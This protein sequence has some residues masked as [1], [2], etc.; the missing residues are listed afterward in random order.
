M[1]VKPSY[2]DLWSFF[3]IQHLSFF[4]GVCFL[5]LSLGPD[6]WCC[7]SPKHLSSSL[8]RVLLYWGWGPFGVWLWTRSTCSM[9]SMELFE[10]EMVPFMVTGLSHLKHSCEF[11]SSREQDRKTERDGPLQPNWTVSRC[12]GQRL[13]TVLHTPTDKVCCATYAILIQLLCLSYCVYGRSQRKVENICFQVGLRRP[14]SGSLLGKPFPVSVDK[15]WARWT[16][17]SPSKIT[18]SLPICTCGV[19]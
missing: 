17:L 19:D 6:S 16:S 4:A 18:S 7:Q 8:W 14:L 10:P 1:F 13:H 5:P 15:H 2:C 9:N 12:F 3:P 11:S